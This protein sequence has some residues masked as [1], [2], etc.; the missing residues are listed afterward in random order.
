MFNSTERIIKKVSNNH[1]PFPIEIWFQPLFQL[2]HFKCVGGEI[3]VRGKYL[4]ESILPFQFILQLEKHGEGIVNLGHFVVE[5]SF[6]YIS[7]FLSVENDNRLY[8]INV[9]RVELERENYA[10]AV[11]MM[12]DESLIAPA[13]II[14]EIT[15][16]DSELT[17]LMISNLNKLQGHGFNIAW[18]DVCNIDDFLMKNEVFPGRYIK[19]DRSLLANTRLDEASKII[20][21]AHNLNITIIA[22]GVQTMNQV[23]FLLKENVTL[24]QGYLFSRPIPKEI[25]SAK[26]G[27]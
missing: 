2:S 13:S 16:N 10:D 22:E 12:G 21:E 1:K 14:L 3:L 11:I 17:E 7:N 20:K 18:G 8:N 27:S 4:N 24:G 15:G 19:L 25:Y 5:E 23:S 26:F 6:K 9:S